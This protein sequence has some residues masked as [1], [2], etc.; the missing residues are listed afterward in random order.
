M[1]TNFWAERGCWKWSQSDFLYAE[2]KLGKAL[3][4]YP[5]QVKFLYILINVR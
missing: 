1:T 3:Q 4:F 5:K 2:V